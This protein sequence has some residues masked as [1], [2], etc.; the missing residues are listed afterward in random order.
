MEDAPQT[1]SASTT[2]LPE[3][4][5]LGGNSSRSLS[6]LPEDLILC[7]ELIRQQQETLLQSQRR[8]EKLEHQLAQLLRA[9]YGPR[10]E[11][12]DEAQLMLFAKELLE[13]EH[14]S[15][16][17][18]QIDEDAP[19]K[20]KS[21]KR[22][23]RKPLP[24]NLP[25][26]RVVHELP[27]D[28]LACPCCKQPRTRAVPDNVFRAAGF[29]PRGLAASSVARRAVDPAHGN[30][31]CSK[32]S[33]EVSEQLEYVPASLFVIEH[34]R[35]TYVCKNCEAHLVTAD[36]PL[37]PIDKGLPGPGLLAHV[38]TSKY[39]DHCVQGQ[40]VSEMR[41][42]PSWPGDRIRPQTSPNCGG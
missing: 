17:D 3:G 20:G 11:R 15:A 18:T 22:R 39:C 14:D 35:P 16:S 31:K 7:H 37:Q 6:S 28:Q 42:G 25:R 41:E 10:S 29:S 38:I 32:I 8:M 33:E 4:A 23:G 40:A 27:D 2:D 12:I 1:S 19:P 36:K 30:G 26:K 13:G 21:G 34:V 24:K 9:R 5:T